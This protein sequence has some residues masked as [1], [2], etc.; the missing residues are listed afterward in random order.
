MTTICGHFYLGL[1]YRVPLA[2]YQ[3]PTDSTLHRTYTSKMKGNRTTQHSSQLRNDVVESEPTTSI[4]ETARIP[5]R[6]R[7]NQRRCQSSYSATYRNNQPHRPAVVTQTQ[8]LE[9]S[10][11]NDSQPRLQIISPT[12]ESE[13][14]PTH[15]RRIVLSSSE[16][17]LY[18]T[19]DS[20]EQEPSYT[21]SPPE[22]PT[23]SPSRNSSASLQTPESI[24]EAATLTVPQC[25]QKICNGEAILHTLDKNKGMQALQA[26]FLKSL[27]SNQKSG[28]VGIAHCPQCK[29]QW[30]D[31][32]LSAQL[33]KHRRRQCTQCAKS[34]TK[35][36][37]PDSN[38]R[39]IPLQTLTRQNKMDP[40]PQLD[41][42]L[43]PDLNPIEEMLIA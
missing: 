13:S 27:T 1:F 39:R 11:D 3:F 41:H 34:L 9:E 43:L 24:A 5:L 23:T 37:I 35:F 42:L 12:Q 26:K 2:L 32:Q 22:S 18:L 7:H 15:R 10:T 21:E 16:E 8:D 31:T 40:W 19:S 38:G 20:E 28:L 29:E 36:S 30:L 25:L 33:L 6:S 17:Q 4:R 14:P